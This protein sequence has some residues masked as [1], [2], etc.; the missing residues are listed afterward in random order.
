[1]D[2]MIATNTQTIAIAGYNP[3]TELG[4]ACFQSG[5]DCGRPSVNRVHTVNIHVVWKAATA[6]DT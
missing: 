3:Y 2:G 4:P 1:M 5:C 6:S